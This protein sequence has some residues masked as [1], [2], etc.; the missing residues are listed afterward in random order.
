MS[1]VKL[2]NEVFETKTSILKAGYNNKNTY[3]D[4]SGILSN[5][6]LK[7]IAIS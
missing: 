2:F 1:S 6:P 4:S 3:F 7:N 5:I